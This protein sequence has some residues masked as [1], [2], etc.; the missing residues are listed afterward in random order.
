MKKMK[1]IVSLVL[2]MVMVVAMAMTTFA[3]ETANNSTIN[4]KG[5]I[6]ISNTVT[7]A[8][9]SIYRIFDLESYDT[10]DTSV[11][12]KGVYSYKVNRAWNGF[13]SGDGAAYVTVD[14]NGYVTWKDSASAADFATKAM[15]YAT[16]NDIDAVATE[17]ATGKEVKFEEL[18]LGYYLVDS[19][20]GT[21]CGL[22]TTNPDITIIEKNSAPTLEKYVK[23]DDWGKRN[24]ADID[25]IVEF[26]AVI[27]VQGYAEDYVMHDT[28]S[29][30][31]TYTGVSKVT[32]N[33][34]VVENADNAA[35]VVNDSTDGGC[36]FE[37][38]FTDAFCESLE[39]GDVIEVYYTAKLNE[40]AVVLGDGNPNTAYLSYTDNSGASGKTPDSITKTY[41]YEVSVLKYANGNE[42]KKLAGATFSLYTDKA[43][44]SAISFNK[45]NSDEE[46]YKVDAEGS[47]TAIT[48]TTSGTFKIEGL[49][50]GTYYLKETNAPDGYNEL[51][52]VIE[53]KI[54]HDGKVYNV[55]TNEENE[56]VETEVDQVKVNNNSGTLLPSTGGMGTTVIYLA[57]IILV[58]AAVVLLA[59]KRR[60]SSEN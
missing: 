31:L 26:K 10:T 5:S 19:T 24:D 45:P 57:G 38:V 41:T 59:A 22:D 60:M 37:V 3:S 17:E 43:C 49:D 16:A 30:G 55:T 46:I 32:K 21:L 8:T 28:M 23:E 4:T 2:A 42:E 18:D 36:T 34:A 25:D 15:V 53:I 6:T 47:V 50:E 27:T 12:E 54:D 7:G 40:N 52:S 13:I 33:E 58:L 44:T 14:D 1:K 56:P 51:G 39:S 9:Y 48:T 11:Y 35:Y 20:V 29:D